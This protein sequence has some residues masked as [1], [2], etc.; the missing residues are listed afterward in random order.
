[1][2][3]PLTSF[4]GI[5]P[6]RAEQ[7]IGAGFATVDSIAG[8]HLDDLVAVPGIGPALAAGLK[9]EA[10]GLLAGGE[11]GVAVEAELLLERA[12]D[13]RRRAKRLAKKAARKKGKKRK[14]LSRKAAELQAK[15]K[16]ARRAAK[17]LLAG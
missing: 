8:A 16:K 3:T 2:A 11:T 7:L 17:K 1:M 6:Q 9:D 4:R 5:G 13:L 15:A 12:R 10:S 14:R